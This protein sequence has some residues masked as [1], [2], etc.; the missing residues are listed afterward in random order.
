VVV[1][2]AGGGPRISVSG[3]TVPLT[4]GPPAVSVIVN[5]LVAVSNDITVPAFAGGIVG[6]VV[7]DVTSPNRLVWT[8]RACRARVW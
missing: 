1:V 5:T 2:V 8:R 6:E 3:V 7:V 4:G